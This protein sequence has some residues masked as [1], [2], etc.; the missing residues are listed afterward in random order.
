MKIIVGVL[1]FF[2]IF[3]ALSSP[4]DAAPIFQ[5]DYYNV[6]IVIDKD[7]T[8]TVEESANLVIDGEFHGLRRDIPTD[9]FCTVGTQTCGGFRNLEILEVKDSKGNVLREGEYSLYTYENED[10]NEKFLRIERELFADGRFVTDY[11]EGWTIKY[12]VYGGLGNLDE[13]TYFYWNVLPESRGGYTQ[14]SRITITL[15]TPIR[16]SDFQFFDIFSHNADTTYS[17]NTVQVDIDGLSDYSNFTVAYRFNAGEIDLPATLKMDLAPSIGTLVELDDLTFDDWSGIA[18]YLPAGDFVLKVSHFGYEDLELPIKLESGKTLDLG[19]V[20]LTATPFM[21]MFTFFMNIFLLLCCLALPLAAFLAY[22]IYD[23]NGRDNNPLKTIIPLFTPPD[24]VK[25]YLAS[26]LYYEE[27]KNKMISAT[28]VDLAVRGIIKIKEESKN[29]FTLTR[30]ED[31]TK[32]SDLSSKEND[33]ISL[34]FDDEYSVTTSSLKTPSTTRAN[35]YRKLIEESY[36]ELVSLGYFNS[37]PQNT[38]A[39][40][41]GYSVLLSML[42]VVLFVGGS[43]ILTSIIGVIFLFVPGIW[44]LV[45][46]ISIGFVARHMPAKTEA[47]SKIYNHLQGFRMYL[48][49]AERFRLKGLEPEEFEKYLSYAMVFDVEKEWAEKFKDLYNHQPEW[50]EGNFSTFDAIYL[51]NAMGNLSSSFNPQTL[52]ASVSNTSGSG[53]SGSSSSFGGFSGGGGGG[54]SSGAW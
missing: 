54:G 40:Y 4:V 45:F 1:S 8:F 37:S 25:P 32:Y 36:T 16:R 39:K 13:G 47:G 7:S 6:D 41:A 50:L 38:R 11:E 52:G 34:I 2:L 49:T 20:A 46:G 44:L 10:T 3:F 35:K 15:P 23:K 30:V 5:Y 18:D 43:F 22:W 12:R 9:N 24:G 17:N 27:F 48:Y 31:E 51:A 14:S 29:D 42:G 26:N 53:W 19:T 21:S 33:I 28:V